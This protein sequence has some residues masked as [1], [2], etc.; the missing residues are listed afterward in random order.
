MAICKDEKKLCVGEWLFSGCGGGRG[1][2]GE[3]E[4][5]AFGLNLTKIAHF[6]EIRVSHPGA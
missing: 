5:V 4:R 1:D 2:A 3:D 6:C